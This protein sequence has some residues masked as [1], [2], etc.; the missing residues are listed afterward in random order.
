MKKRI[1]FGL[2]LIGILT[3]SS[4]G[5]QNSKAGENTESKK[6]SFWT[7]SLKNDFLKKNSKIEFEKFVLSEL[8]IENEYDKNL[9]VLSGYIK[10]KE[11]EEYKN[12]KT[13]Q[14]IVNIDDLVNKSKID[15]EKL[16]GIPNHKEKVNPS[17]TP[18]PCDKYNYINDL[19]EIVYINGKADWIT[20]NSTPSFVKIDKSKYQSVNKFD[21]YTYV[22]VNTK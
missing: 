6:Q 16:I 3:F 19:I 2:S 12:S 8:I 18:C 20:V 1:L 4:C 21:D 10:T 5:N 13:K 15:I 14:F 22:K 9:A 17:N 11:F 7:D